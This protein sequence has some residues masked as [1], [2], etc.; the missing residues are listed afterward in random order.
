[1]EKKKSVYETL[2][3]ISVKEHVK[4]KGKLAYISWATAWALLKQN[5]P[6]SER[7]IYENEHTGLN[8]FT[9]GK[10]SWVKVGIKVEGLEHIDMLPVIDYR[11]ASVINDKMTSMD[12]NTAIQRATAKAIAMHG[13]AINLYRGEDLDGA[14]TPVEPKPL[15]KLSKKDKEAWT[16]VVDFLESQHALEFKALLVR[17]EKR[18]ILSDAIKK[19]LSESHA[20]AVAANAEKS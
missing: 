1:M 13:L 16:K 6:N 7:I 8:F 3:A 2:S 14:V 11:N 9:D 20:K 5:Y 18:Y 4:Y 12:V 10:T 15:P 19:S 17:I